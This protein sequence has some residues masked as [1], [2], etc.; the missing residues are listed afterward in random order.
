MSLGM[1]GRKAGM[2]RIFDSSGIS[3]PVTVIALGPNII[4]QIK[5]LEKDGYEAVQISYGSKRESKLSKP[6]VGHYKKNSINPGEGLIEFRINQGE[7]DNLK[8]GQ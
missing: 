6:L 7:L 4:T 1:I 8:V 3:V 2:T 5:T